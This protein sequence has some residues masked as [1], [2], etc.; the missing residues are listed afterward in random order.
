MFS[1]HLFVMLDISRPFTGKNK[2]FQMDDGFFFNFSVLRK[3]IIYTLS[4]LHVIKEDL[5]I[6]VMWWFEFLESGFG[7]RDLQLC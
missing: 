3:A 7:F 6:Q 2:Q 1:L 5:F 4:Y